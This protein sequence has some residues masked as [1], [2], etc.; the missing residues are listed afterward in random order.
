MTM[1][2]YRTHEAPVP[3]MY[4]GKY[5]NDKYT[6]EELGTLYANDVNVRLKK[7]ILTIHIQRKLVNIPW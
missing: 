2:I 3:D 4:R 1:L 6:E 5:R 7:L